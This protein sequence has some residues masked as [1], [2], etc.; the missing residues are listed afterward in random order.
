MC[1]HGTPDHGKRFQGKLR[2]L[3]TEHGESWAEDDAATHTDPNRSIRFTNRYVRG[4]ITDLACEHPDLSWR[5]ARRL[6]AEEA[7][8]LPLTFGKRYPWAKASWERE[9]MEE[10]EQ[11]VRREAFDAAWERGQHTAAPQNVSGTWTGLGPP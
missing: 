9:A 10:Q 2:R 6:L 4:I 8:S 3:A 5:E 1:H 11:R 7:V